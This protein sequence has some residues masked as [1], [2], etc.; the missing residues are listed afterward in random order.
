MPKVYCQWSECT[1]NRRGRCKARSISME[2][3]YHTPTCDNYE[4][5]WLEPWPVRFADVEVGD[6]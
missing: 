1:H 3:H 4:G 6:E 2:D 5:E